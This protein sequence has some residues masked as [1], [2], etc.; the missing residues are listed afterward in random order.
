MVRNS[1]YDIDAI[2]AEQEHVSVIFRNG[3]YDLGK[4]LLP[5]KINTQDKTDHGNNILLDSSSNNN[6]TH[7]EDTNNQSNN[8]LNSSDAVDDEDTNEVFSD[9]ENDTIRANVNDIPANTRVEM[10][11]WLARVL[12]KRQFVTV[13]LPKWVNTLESC[14]AEWEAVN[15]K[16]IT[17][18]FYTFG[19]DLASFIYNN[20]WFSTERR[21]ACEKLQ[22][23]VL[24]AFAKRFSIILNSSN[25]LVKENMIS[26]TRKL[27][28][29]EEQLFRLAQKGVDEYDKWKTQSVGKAII[30]Q[31]D[32]YTQNSGLR[33][34]LPTGL[35]QRPQELENRE[36]QGRR[37][38]SRLNDGSAR[39]TA[40]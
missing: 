24:R 1:Y 8:S 2:L 14:D 5:Q 28:S 11:F 7:D 34:V 31:S 26:I 22:E 13:E 19:H 29:N 18:H 27:S 37:K 6:I 30:K 4:V 16:A 33:F 23:Y 3:A 12:G 17:P 15:L 35:A 38:R 36:E 39:E 40:K 32:L 21:T 9:D 25:G 20:N 10:P